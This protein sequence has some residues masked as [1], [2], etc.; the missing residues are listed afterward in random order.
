MDTQTAP[1]AETAEFSATSITDAIGGTERHAPQERHTAEVEP[2]VAPEPAPAAQSSAQPAAKA[3]PA[4][5]AAPTPAPAGQA[6]D[7]PTPEAPKEPKWYRDHLA[8]TN[9]ELAAMRQEN[10]RLRAGRQPPPQER[11]RQEQSEIPDPIEDP[12]GYHA[13]ITG[14]F[15]RRQQDFELRTTLSFSERFARQ[16]HGHEAFEECQAWLTTKP[17]LADWCVMQPDPW[18]AAFAQYTRD[19][20][21]EEIGDDPNA[22]RERETARIRAEVEAELNAGGGG[23][24]PQHIPARRTMT[25]ARDAPPAPA[26][27]VRS[28]VGVERDGRGRFQGQT[29]MGSILSAGR[30]AG[31]SVAR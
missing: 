16:Q 25:P 12:A 13:Y 11:Q 31:R 29:P 22:W 8:K 18:G 10:E 19:R 27:S 24:E 15:N 26:S 28:A 30:P 23:Q 9:R 3:A 20:L 17:E 6:G 1:A 14:D 7:P 5:P 4:A 2:G 21:V